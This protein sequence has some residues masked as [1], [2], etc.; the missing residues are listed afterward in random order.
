MSRFFTRWL[1]RSSRPA[2][3]LG[4]QVEALEDRLALSTLFVDAG[5]ALTYTAGFGVAN[6]LTI[7]LDAATDTY[8]FSDVEII[9]APG[10][11]GNGTTSVS[12]PNAR[13]SSMKLLLG[14]QAD[15]LKVEATKDPI[16]VQAG[17]GDDTITLVSVGGTLDG[18]QTPLNVAGDDGNDTL[19]VNDQ[20]AATGKSYTLTANSLT[21]AGVVIVNGLSTLETLNLNT[22]GLNDAIAVQGTPSGTAAAVNAGFGDDTMTAGGAVGGLN[23]VL[24]N[25][26]FDGQQGN[27]VLT[28]DDTGGSAARAFTVTSSA[29]LR[30]TG[31]LSVSAVNYANA[32]GV[33]V[34]AGAFDDQF[35]VASTRFATPVTLNTGAGDDIVSLGRGLVLT[36]IF[37]KPTLGP[38]QGAVTVNGQG[39]NDLLSLSDAGSII[40]RSYAVTSSSVVSTSSIAK[41]NYGTVERLDIE[42]TPFDDLIKVQSTAVGTVT[43][44]HG[45]EGFDS[46]FVGID[47]TSFP[48]ANLG[49]IQGALTFDFGAG[50]DRLSLDDRNN[51]FNQAYSVTSNSVS[52]SGIAP[53]N[54]SF[55]GQ[56]TLTLSANGATNV[57]NVLSTAANTSVFVNLG[58]GDDTINVG[59]PTFFGGHSM[60]GIQGHLSIQGQDG[61]D[62]LNLLDQEVPP[63]VV[64]Q[65][66]QALPLPAST[67]GQTYT[68]N[69][70]SVSRSGAAGIDYLG[71][72]NVV[73]NTTASDDLVTVNLPGLSAAVTVNAG[74]GDDTI[75]LV[76]GFFTGSLTVNGQAGIDRLDYSA[77]TSGVRV[78]LA[79]GTATRLTGLSG[80]EDVVG[81][82]ANDILVGDGGANLLMGGPGRDILIGG[83]GVD[84]LLGGT[85]EDILIG[86]GTTLGGAALEAVMAEWARTDVAYAVRI[87]H[88]KLGGGLNGAVKLDQ[89]KLVE[90]N[91]RDSLTGIA[92]AL[93]WF[94]LTGSDFATDLNKP[95]F[96]Q[97][98]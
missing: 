40:G 26:T 13:V 82:A 61:K 3:K 70:T 32:E 93:D 48:V 53:I 59:R 89:T 85:D 30:S 29:V 34:N 44:I 2:R 47:N 19:T 8:K 97:V 81:G 39:G 69:S 15:T 83:A 31:F 58:F 77:F 98:N 91:A 22:T 50:N 56:G 51:G 75:R 46:A 35:G 63:P 65:V 28:V 78:N 24:S 33:V 23:A 38:L 71:I 20:G 52:R 11:L 72:E 37:F 25:V 27:D 18:I 68:V 14:D 45:L 88:L 7:N 64:T 79:Q 41:I 4:L 36:P 74:S 54:Y 94:F 9:N 57:V 17:T 10:F 55:A 12:V 42:T 73:L 92:D 60:G 96:E 62:V 95:G 49:S 21:R 6:R 80:I 90:D 1:S 87:Q 16:Q 66:G 84:Q 5:G 67:V 43:T 86:N 76:D